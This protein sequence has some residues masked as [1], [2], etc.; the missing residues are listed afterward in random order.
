MQ[1]MKLVEAINDLRSELKRDNQDLRREVLRAH[2]A[3]IRYLIWT[4]LVMGLALGGKDLLE[5]M[6][7]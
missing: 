7:Q 5:L 6:L 1:D 3:L 4:I 2:V